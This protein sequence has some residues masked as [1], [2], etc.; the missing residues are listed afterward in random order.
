MSGGMDRTPNRHRD[1]KIGQLRTSHDMRSSWE[2][3]RAPPLSQPFVD[4][5]GGVG[6]VRQA[7][8]ELFEIGHD[9]YGI[10]GGEGSA[11]G[12]VEVQSRRMPT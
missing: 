6:S 12:A 9:D 10:D 8:S 4:G 3:Q 7:T 1:Q 5:T 11:Y 2:A